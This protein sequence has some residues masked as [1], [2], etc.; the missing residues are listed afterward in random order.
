MLALSCALATSTLHAQTSDTL[1]TDAQVNS[2][3]STASAQHSAITTVVVKGTPAKK[4]KN[5]TPSD[6]PASHATITKAQAEATINVVNSEDTIKYL[7]DLLVRKRFI[8]DTQAP[9]ATRTTGINASARSLILADGVLLSTLIN[10]NNG[11]GSPQWFMVAPESID[12]IDVMYGPY[13]AAYAGNSYGAVLNIT[14]RMPQTFEAG[15]TIRASNQPFS[16]YGTKTSANAQEYSAYIGN[17]SG[18]FSWLLSANELNSTSQPITFGT[19]SQS[20][21]PASSSLPVVSGSYPTLNRTGSPMQVIGAGNLTHTIQDDVTLKLAYDITPYISASYLIGYWQ[22]DASAQSRSYLTLNGTPY[23]GGTSGNVNIGGY[24][25]SASTI[26]GQYSSNEVHQQHLMQSITLKGQDPSAL[27]W[28]LIASNFR[29]LQDTT[30]TSTGAYP[31][32]MTG[33]A[34][35][36]S[37]ASGTGWT[38]LDLSASTPTAWLDQHVISTGLHGDWYRLQNPTW[39]TANWDGGVPTSLYSDSEGKTQTQALWLQDVWAVRPDLKATLGARYEDWQA[40][41]GFNLTTAASKTFPI[42]QP[43]VDQSGLSPKASLHWDMTSAWS[44]TGSVGKALRFPT[45]GELYQSVQTGSIYTQANPYLQP[46]RVWSEELALEHKTDQ[47]EVRVSLFQED[48]HHALISQTAL[49][50]GYATPVS[51]TQNVDHTRQRGVELSGQFQDVAIHGLDLSGSLSYVNARILADSS[52]VPSATLPN[53]SAVGSHTP[54]VPNWRAT[55]VAAYRP[56][57]HWTWTLAGR[58]VGRQYATV[59]NTDIYTHTYQGFDPFFV[60]DARASYQF[61]RHWQAAL[62]VDNLNNR[63]YFLYHPFPERT[64]LA[65]LRYKY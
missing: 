37:D 30:G 17:R 2:D 35:R 38:T 4:K 21:T 39:N 28:Q 53:A 22:N 9:L 57:D 43:K 13:S 12:H 15:A 19:V 52:Y 46:E 26:A 10:N 40:N 63:S 7:P 49:I 48:V 42:A 24:S 41:N 1:A 59:D 58:Y 27:N 33:G 65:E 20:T 34:G 44:L 50:T 16:L 23:Y 45:V 25:Y 47:H 36:I 54:Y 14:T 56:N 3:P 6:F 55:L 8:G 62:G 11:N 64:Y 61:N 5:A 29:Y 51:Y 60:M 32:A 18:D 31:A